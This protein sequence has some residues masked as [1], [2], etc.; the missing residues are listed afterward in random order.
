MFVNPPPMEAGSPPSRAANVARPATAGVPL[1]AGARLPLAFIALGLGAFAIANGA[2]A[3]RPELLL[4]PFAHPSVVA[5]AH[6]W[7][8][9]FLLSV[10]MGAVYQL[11]PV[12][13]GTALRLPLAAAWTHFGAHGA[14]VTLLVIGF[15][16]GRIEWIAA[17]GGADATRAAML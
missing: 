6:L 2:L 4:L 5:L 17:G 10:S 14:G 3:V 15:A 12:V 8:P 9:G 1:V 11:M 13:L 16:A 7:L